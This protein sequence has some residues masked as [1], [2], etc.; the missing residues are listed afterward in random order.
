MKTTDIEL[1]RET[2]IARSVVYSLLSRLLAY[3]SLQHRAH[4]EGALAPVLQGLELSPEVDG[5]LRAA[6][7]EYAASLDEVRR[8]HTLLFP[9]I[10]SQ[11][12]P[13]YE[14]A[15]SAAD[16]FR[17]AH[18][19]ADVAGFYRA[20]GLEVGGVERERPDH[21]TTELEF[22]AFMAAKEAWAI[23]HLGD[24]Q[25]QEC[26]RTQGRFL[27]EHLGCWGA[28]LGLRIGARATHPLYRAVGDLLAA[29]LEEDMGSLGLAPARRYEHP[30][31]PEEPD[32]GE[33]ALDAAPILPAPT[34]R[35]E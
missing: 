29:W 11:D 28:S 2:A 1:E 5:P 27:S 31:P 18:T 14:T 30:V 33:C 13:A 22:M 10:E 35:R 12:C 24:E 16:V 23:A 17:Q 20:H 7:S 21:I 15:Y 9:P 34:I 6:L 26:R 32:D 3:P 4:I 25:I 8:A 19:M